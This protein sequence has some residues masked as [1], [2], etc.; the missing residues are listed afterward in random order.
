M[1]F[2][3]VIFVFE[4]FYNN[5]KNLK[6]I[7]NNYTIRDRLSRIRNSTITLLL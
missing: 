1:D 6:Y 5:V 3:N 4:S 7:K 2:V